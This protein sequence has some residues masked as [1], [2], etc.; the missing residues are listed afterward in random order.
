MLVF[1]KGVLMKIQKPNVFRLMLF[2][3]LFALNCWAQPTTSRLDGLVQ[4]ASGGVVPAAKVMLINNETQFA[5]NRVT[6]ENGFY[7]FPL[8]TPGN[9]RITVEKTGFKTA[10]VNEIKV[11]V[12]I[13]R[14]VDV[15]LEVGAISETVLVTADRA[16]SLINTI[17][18][19]LNTV[20]DQTQI[21][22]LPIPGRNPLEF[23]LMQAGVTARG[24]GARE[25]SVNGL[26]GT[27]QNLTLDGINNQDN[28]IRTDSFFGV[29]PVKES[30]VEE[31]NITTSNADVDAGIGAGQ[32]RMVTRSGTSEF[33]AEAFYYHQNT[34][35]NANNFFNNAAGVKREAVLNHQYGFNVGGPIIKNKIFFFVDWEEERSPGSVSVVRSVLTEQARNGFYTYQRSDNGQLETVNLFSLT[36]VSPDPAIA[37]LIAKTPLPNDTTVGDGTNTAGYR[38]NSPSK[39]TGKWLSFKIDYNPLRNHY[40]SAVLHQFRYSLPNDPFNDVDA[41][42]PGLSGGGQKSTRYLGSLSLRSTPRASM[43]NELRFGAQYAPVEFF[44]NEKFSSGYQLNLPLIDNPIR[45]DMAQG[46]NAPVYELGDSYTWTRGN[47][48]LKFGGGIRWTSVDSTNDAGILPVY[49]V[50]FGVGNANPLGSVA[51][52]GGIE[53]ITAAGDQ[54]AL[55]GGYVGAVTQ[56]FNIRNRTSGFVNDFTERRKYAQRY[57]DLFAGDTWRVTPGFSLDLGLRWEYHGIPNE[58]HGLALLP[59]NGTADLY[60][61]DAV[62]DFAGRGTGHDFFDGDYNN[63]A[64][65]IGIAYRPFQGKS[66]VIRAGYSIN[67]VNDNNF[68]SVDNAAAGNDGLRQTV[69]RSDLAGTVSGGGIVP[70]DT[71][72]FMVPRTIS[73]NLALDPT[74]ALYAIDKNYRTP[75]VQQWNLSVQHEIFK[76]TAL[77]IRYVGNHGV[78]MARAIDANQLMLHPEFVADWRRARSNLIANGDPYSGEP[79]TVIPNLGFSGFLDIVP[80]LLLTNEIGSYVGD[81]LAPNRVFFFSDQGGADFGSTIPATYFYR[82]PNAFVSDYLGNLSYSS[83]HALQMEIRRR[84]SRG[85]A[86]QANYTF[87][88]V[89]TDFG[90]GQSNFSSYMDNAQPNLEKMRPDFDITHTFN[91]N[92]GYTMPF[93]SGRYFAIKNRWLDSV[94]GGWEV[95]GIIRVRSGEVINIVSQRA[96]INRFGRSGKNTVDLLGLSIP[97]LQDRTGVYRD[98]QGRIVMFDPAL[99]GADGRGSATYFTNPDVAKAGSLGLSPVSGPWYFNTD[100]RLRKQFRTSKVREGSI[101]EI[102]ADFAN[103]FNHTNFNITGTPGGQ[104]ETVS[105]YNGQSINSTSFGLINSAFSPRQMEV[106]LKLSF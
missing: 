89:L 60:N 63:V 57:F 46:R 7:V 12:G 9:Y 41:V 91:L 94:V 79:L 3:P 104:D 38:F 73:D 16:G 93:G 90:G 10:T 20:V 32:T 44:T 40:I 75:Y 23:A 78:K 48:S 96:T 95:G 65:S 18:A 13:P 85:L 5:D 30:F 31:F 106:G 92:F 55:L 6:N 4:D 59:V 21:D 29:L 11:D 36:G 71:P 88:K 42:F 17:N 8:V 101:L 2:V 80:D 43:T 69:S 64:P 33:H 25:A 51:F 26:R 58:V 83:Y 22:S 19:E 47:H 66:T 27:Y 86:F 45:N 81:F 37:S 14:T 34:A 74:T 84:F 24:D 99:I 100:L 39:S 82:N 98:S 102:R 70:I 54:L 53:D 15:T 62:L 61:P 35:L 68:T 97:Q 103:L 72:Q 76:D 49:D 1:E 56:A 52:P 77:E 105:V 50:E 87:G 67:Y 28:F